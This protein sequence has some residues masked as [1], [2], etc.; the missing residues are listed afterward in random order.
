MRTRSIVLGTVITLFFASGVAEAAE[1]SF[2]C[3]KALT[4]VKKLICEDD[5][6]AAEDAIIA[7][8]Y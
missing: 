1:P 8:A 2:D 5:A 6:P 4:D 3:F 7:D